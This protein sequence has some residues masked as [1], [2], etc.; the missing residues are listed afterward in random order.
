MELDTTKTA[1]DNLIK[2]ITGWGVDNFA[3]YPWRQKGNVWHAIVAEIMLQRTGADQ[4]VPVYNNFVSRYPTPLSFLEDPD[5]DVFSTL[6]LYWRQQKLLELAEVLQNKPP[7]LDGDLTLLPGVGAYVAAAVRSLHLG[8]PDVIIDSNVVRLYGRYFGFATDPE[9]RRK[10]WFIALA[11]EL[12]PLEASKCK[13]YNYGIIDFTR[14][15]CRPVPRC[16][17]CFL[18]SFCIRGQS[19]ED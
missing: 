17:D 2:G 1:A 15:V 5:P 11:K 6:G 4:V 16:A 13:S 8:V 9:T 19:S 18:K 12:T 10:S 14:T 7:L 3:N